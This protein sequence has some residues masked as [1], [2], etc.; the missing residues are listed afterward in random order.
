M[1]ISIE[2]PYGTKNS[3]KCFIEYN[4]HNAVKPLYL[5][6]STNNMLKN[7]M[8]SPQCLS[9]LMIENCLKKYNEI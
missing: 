6:T 2:G 3:F 4:C 8:V 9:R 7:L 5:K 1:L